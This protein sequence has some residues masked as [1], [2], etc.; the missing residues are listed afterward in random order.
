M[1]SVGLLSAAQFVALVVHIASGGM[2]SGGAGADGAG[3]A[4]GSDRSDRELATVP[5]GASAAPEERS[6][7]AYAGYGTWV[8]VYDYVPAMQGSGPGPEVTPD[9]VDEMADQGVR[10]LYLQA[11]NDH[12]RT[13]GSVVDEELVGEFLTRAHERDVRVVGWYLPRF[14]SIA[15]DLSFLEGI[16]SFEADGHRF[17]GVAVDIE[18]TRSVPDARERSERLV[19]LSRRLRDE[20]GDDPLGAIVLPPVQL[21]EVNR[22][23]WPRFPW[24]ELAPL[25]DVWLPMGY[26]TDRRASSGWRDAS[27]YTVENASRVR[28]NL[29]DED[30]AVHVIGGIGH[31][32]TASDMTRFVAAAVDVEAMGASVYDWASLSREER[33]HLRGAVAEAVAG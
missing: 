17:D 6:V 2:G 21:E 27:R 10:T 31:D 24:E 29:G 22:R 9:D 32:A 8:D 30:A 18:W 28:A 19:E 16:A 1:A 13:P 15:R 7:D 20:V 14:A 11:A 5:V 25:Y 12:A 4:D 26:W 33:R 3:G 23:M